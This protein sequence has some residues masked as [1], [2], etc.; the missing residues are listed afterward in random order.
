[1]SEWKECKLANVACLVK[2]TYKPKTGDH[3]PY[4]G[5]EHIQEQGLRLLSVGDSDSVTSQASA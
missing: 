4:I 1:M 5:L 2:D 3:L